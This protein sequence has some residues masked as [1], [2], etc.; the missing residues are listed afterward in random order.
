ME[1]DGEKL[2]IDYPASW[3][4]RIIGEGEEEDLRAAIAVVAGDAQHVVTLANR[5]QKA[6]YSSFQ[7]TIEVRDEAHRLAV[8]EELRKL[9][10]V[11][12]VL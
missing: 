5:S 12:Y 1:I 8:F 4:Y 10:N 6:R 7:L 2:H 3:D 9:P 11:R